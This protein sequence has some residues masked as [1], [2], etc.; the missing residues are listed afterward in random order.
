[1]QPKPPTL[2]SMLT[3]E[4]KARNTKHETRRPETRDPNPE[5]RDPKPKTRFQRSRQHL[6]TNSDLQKATR[7]RPKPSIRNLLTPSHRDRLHPLRRNRPK[8]LRR[9][10]HGGYTKVKT[11]VL[12]PR[13]EKVDTGN[14]R[15]MMGAC[16]LRDLVELGAGVNPEP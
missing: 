10:R 4:P 2:T 11:R 3:S 7:I 13:P 9:N 12:T 6:R 5:T 16:F 8:P 15:A 1:M 14:L